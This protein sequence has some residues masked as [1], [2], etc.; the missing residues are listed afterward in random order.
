MS[1]ECDGVASKPSVQIVEMPKLLSFR[2]SDDRAIPSAAAAC[3][4]LPPA[5]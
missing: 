2:Y 4:L 5:S 3:T 1:S